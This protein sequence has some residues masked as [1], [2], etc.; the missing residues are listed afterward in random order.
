MNR[1]DIKYTVRKL[2]LDGYTY[3]EIINTIKVQISKSTLSNWCKG[4]VLTKNYYQKIKILNKLNI[5]KAQKLAVITNKINRDDLLNA[6]NISNS[7]YLKFISLD[8]KRL[9]LCTLY[10][11]EGAKRKSSSFLGLASSDSNIIKLYLTLLKDCYEIDMNKFRVR[12]QLRHDQNI[13]KITNY[14]LGVTKIPR[15]QLYRPYIDK[16]TINQPTKK[17]EYKGVCT[18]LYFDCRLQ[19]ELELLASQMIKCVV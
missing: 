14:W 17:L 11:A 6:I 13:S 16:R 19:L 15:E 4:L 1:K 5:L 12:I 9:I 3:K 10:L 18:I 2:R 7:K 8:T